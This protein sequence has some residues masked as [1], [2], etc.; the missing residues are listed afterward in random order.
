MDLQGHAG[1]VVACG[2]CL[3]DVEHG[4]LDHVGGGALQWGVDCGAFGEA[5]HVG[6]ARLDVGDGAGAAK[7]GAYLA[8]F[9][10]LFQRFCDEVLHALVAVEVGFDVGAGFFLVDA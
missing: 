9:T 5:A 3:V 7:E 8:C 1:F 10:R 6:V 4:Y 2:E